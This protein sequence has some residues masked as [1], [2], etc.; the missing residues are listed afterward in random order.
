M[1]KSRCLLLKRQPKV[2]RNLSGIPAEKF[3]K[4]YNQ[5]LPV[6][7]SSERKRFSKKN[8]KR[9]IGGGRKKELQLDDQLLLVLIYYR[10]YVSQ[11]FLGLLFNLHNSNV[12]RTIR[13]IEPLLSKI[14]KISQRKIK[15]ELT[16]DQIAEYF[17]DA[18][19]QPINRPKNN[20]RDYYSGKKKK[21]TLKNQI[22]INKNMKITSVS[23]SVEGNK[24][25]KKLYDQSRVYTKGKS[26]IK[27]DLGYLGTERIAVPNKKPKNRELTKEEKDYNK[28]LSSE[29]I[30][31]EHV[32]GK[33]KVFQILSQRF[34]N[35]RAKHALIFKNI[36]GLYN[37]TYT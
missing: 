28:Q 8:R 37:L 1:Q 31:V 26:K 21:H 30:K 11:S 4:L 20:Q 16:E 18:T 22:V 25:D 13:Y 9:N 7:Q 19:E 32:F 3:D 6:Y 33:M 24:H 27:G 15:T 34:R 29:R 10:H 17:I 5:L 2:F 35:P 14:F 36:A 12:S 23:K